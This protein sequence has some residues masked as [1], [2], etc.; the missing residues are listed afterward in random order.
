MF[1]QSLSWRVEGYVLSWLCILASA[2][3]EA[4]A[5]LQGLNLISSLNTPLLLLDREGD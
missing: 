3:F 2:L 4:D 1:T 5:A